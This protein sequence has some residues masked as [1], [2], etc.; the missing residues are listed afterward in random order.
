M[1]R[2]TKTAGK[3]KSKADN[4]GTLRNEA[5]KK[6]GNLPAESPAIPGSEPEKLV[7]ELNVHQIELEM[8]NEALRETQSALEES[9]DEYLD[10]YDFAPAGYMTLDNKAVIEKANLT[11]ATLL[12]VSRRDLIKDRFRKFVAPEDLEV[13]DRF[14]VTVLRREEKQTSDLHLLKGDDSRFRARVESRRIRQEKKDPVIRLM[15]SDITSEKHAE[16]QLNIFQTFTENAR[17]IVLFVRKQ[18]GKIIEANRKA[19]E[20]YGF[21]HDELL[22][23]TIFALRKSDPRKLVERQMAEADATGVL[24]E[25]VHRRKDG[26]DLPVEVNTFSLQLDGEPVLFSIIRDITDR[27]RAEAFRQLSADVLEILNEPAEQ[28]EVIRRV[29]GAIK[30]ATKADAVGIRLMSGDD[31]PY[32]TQEGFSGDFLLKENTLIVRGADEEIC[33]D[34]EGNVSL[35]CMCGLVISGKTDPKNP[36]FTP[37]GS[38]W[39]N[40]SFL[41]L[42]L[43]GTDDPR[44]HPRNTCFHTGFASVAIIPIR[45]NPRQIIGSLQINALRKDCFTPDSIQSLELIAGQIGEALL[46]KQAEQEVNRLTED[47][48]TLIDNVPAMIWYKDTC[49]NFIRVNPAGARAYGIPVKA[50]EGKSA[51]DLFPEAAGKYY[52]DDLEVIGSGL[53]KFGIIE[54]ME[55][56]AGENLWVRTDKIPLKD[57]TGTVTGLVVFTVDITAIKQAEEDLISRSDEVHAANKALT[58]AGDD[59]R[60]KE[61][62]LTASLEEKEALLSEIHH[63][64]KNNLAAFI[65]LLSLE[66]TY[67][68]TPA[69]DQ[70]KKDLQ[71]RARSM[72]LIHETLYMTR[73]FSSVDMGVYLKTLVEQVSATYSPAASIRTIVKVEGVTLDLTRATPCGLI[74]NELITNSFKYAFPPSFD[75][76]AV[77][78]E[79]CTIQVSMT[80]AGGMY[81]LVV[82]DNGIGLPLKFDPA[83]A[84]SLGLKLVNFLSRHQLHAEIEVRADNGTEFIFRLKNT[85]DCL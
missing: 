57:E 70:L 48:K 50:I 20:M 67:E 44:L 3:T 65:S 60:E 81:E 54:Q 23:T 17:D 47:R 41:F 8:Q 22:N 75:C 12:G 79:P 80:Q 33:R 24:F 10:L 25:T 84:K 83:T 72:A 68:D 78:H 16:D 61:T 35:E 58:A 37:G 36:F 32:F 14:F 53:P 11:V 42:K 26:T 9:R 27:K 2:K 1:K 6:L 15:I 49:N 34:S 69:G 40:D 18:D 4:P 62:R 51:Y 85:G 64:V 43:P 71:N 66:G 74:V 55:T 31:F 59:L 30:L 73:N 77:R 38:F 28:K 19:T 56:A 39:T 46:R 5:E 13:W 52:Q 7:H 45:K 29:L 82:G 76:A 21:S 63:R